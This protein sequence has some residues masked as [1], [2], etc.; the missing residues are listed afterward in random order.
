MFGN[1]GPS[2][3]KIILDAIEKG[4]LLFIKKENGK[5]ICTTRRSKSSEWG[6]AAYMAVFP[7]C[8]LLRYDS[9]APVTSR[10]SDLQG[11]STS[12]L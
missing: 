7:L 8:Y 4:P 1:S 10:S 9:E 5:L 12:A 3:V 11:F 6:G 2:S